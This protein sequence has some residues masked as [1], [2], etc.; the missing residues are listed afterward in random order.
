M[1]ID[2]ILKHVVELGKFKVPVIEFR[3]KQG[4]DSMIAIAQFN[5]ERIMIAEGENGV[6]EMVDELGHTYAK[7][8]HK[9]EWMEAAHTSKILVT[10]LKVPIRVAGT[11]GRIV[12]STF[13]FGEIVSDSGTFSADRIDIRRAVDRIA[14]QEEGA[15]KVLEKIHEA[16]RPN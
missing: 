6:V 13:P 3:F 9:H 7:L 8:E 12:V 10:V 15:E 4:T 1:K 11:G 16:V 14:G 2:S 5:P